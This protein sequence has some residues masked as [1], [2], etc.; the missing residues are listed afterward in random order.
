MDHLSPRTESISRRSMLRLLGGAALASAGLVTLGTTDASAGRAWCRKDPEFLI[1][2]ELLHVYVSGPA[3]L[4]E[5]ATGP[6]VVTLH[7]PQQAVDA[8]FIW[9]DEGFRDL[10]YDVQIVKADRLIVDESGAIQFEVQTHVPSD[11]GLE[12]M[13]EAVHEHKSGR[14]EWTDKRIGRTNRDVKLKAKI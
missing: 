1:N 9:A 6:T 5:V 3:E 13:V 14:M 11:E 12:V 8:Q 10:G 2:G 4:D 7:I